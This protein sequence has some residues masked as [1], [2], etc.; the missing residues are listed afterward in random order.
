MMKIETRLKRAKK[1]LLEATTEI[2]ELQSLCQHPALKGYYESDRG[3]YD[4]SYDCYWINLSCPDC[5][6]QLRI[7]STDPKYYTIQFTKIK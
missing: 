7:Y 3:N 1:K 2:E 6:K 5:D 4:P